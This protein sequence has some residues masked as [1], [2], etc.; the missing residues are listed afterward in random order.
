M[1]VKIRRDKDRDKNKDYFAEYR[2]QHREDARL[3]SRLWREINPDRAK[4]LSRKD[5]ESNKGKRVASHKI[6]ASNNKDLVR[7]H[8]KK[9]YYRNR[10]KYIAKN[11]A[12]YA[13]NKE[14]YRARDRNRQALE[15]NA[16]GNHTAEQII[17]LL[18]DQL[19]RCA[20]TFCRTI[21][22]TS[23]KGKFHAD[24]MIPISRGGS[25]DISNIQLLCPLCNRRKGAKTMNEFLNSMNMDIYP[26]VNL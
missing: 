19:G 5:W 2:K 10:E 8:A 16:S 23:G 15:L 22:I 12:H 13:A 9:T 3:R 25:N 26:K 20:A 21:L 7:L 24:H 14:L 11:K 4:T 1:C 18:A 17:N 6:W